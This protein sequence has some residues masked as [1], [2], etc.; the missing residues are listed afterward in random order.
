MR[1]FDIHFGRFKH[2]KVWVKFE[3]KYPEKIGM[4]IAKSVLKNLA[5]IGYRAN[6]RPFNREQLWILLDRFI[7]IIL[8]FMYLLVEAKTPRQYMESYFTFCVALLMYISLM[9]TMVEMPT[10][11]VFIDEIEQVIHESECLGFHLK[12]TFLVSSIIFSNF[13]KNKFKDQNTR[14]LN[15]CMKKPIILRKNSAK[16][17]IL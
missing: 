9:S 13:I 10:M 16:F 12:Y 11:F 14:S 3:R 2:K 15:S 1:Q 4:R 5:S 7:T 6:E 8:Q 17:P